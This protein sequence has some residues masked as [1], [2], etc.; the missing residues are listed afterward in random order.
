MNIEITIVSDF[1]NTRKPLPKSL[2][3]LTG[4]MVEFTGVVRGDENGQPIGGLEYEAYR[5]MAEQTIR[6][7]VE[8][9]GQR[10]PCLF[11]RVIHQIGTVP[12][13]GTAVYVVACATHRAAALGMIGDFMDRLKQDVPIWKGRALDTGGYPLPPTP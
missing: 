1:V 5:P 13:G 4:A 7:I 3:G 12:V 8:D 10:H 11:V 9:L 2:V 6:A